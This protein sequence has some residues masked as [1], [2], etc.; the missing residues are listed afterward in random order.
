MVARV[1]GLIESARLCRSCVVFYDVA[2]HGIAR[3]WCF[4][5]DGFHDYGCSREAFNAYS[6]EWARIVHI[7]LL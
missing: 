1:A 5:F 2:W 6:L 7:C 4:V 3:H